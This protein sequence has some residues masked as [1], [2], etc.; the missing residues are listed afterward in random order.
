MIVDYPILIAKILAIPKAL[1]VI[2]Q[3]RISNVII[4]SDPQ[5]AIKA[6]KGEINPSSQILNFIEDINVLAKIVENINFLYSSRSVNK[7]TD[8]IA[9][10]THHLTLKRFVYHE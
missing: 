5:N 7:L 1:M 3:K 6:I 4:G 8:E 9:K 2:F 10:R